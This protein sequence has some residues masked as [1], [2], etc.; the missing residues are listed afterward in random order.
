MISSAAHRRPARPP[1]DDEQRLRARLRHISVAHPQWGWRKAHAIA[2][3]EGLVTNRKRT[4]RLWL[5]EGLERPPRV[6]KKRRIGSARHQRLHATRPDQ[7]WALDFQ[8]GVT[9]EGRQARFLNVIDEY[10][11]EALAPRAA[12]SFTADATVA[13]LDELITGPG[14]RPEHIRMDNGPELTAHALVDWCRYSG[15][16]AAYIDPASPW[17]NGVCESFNGR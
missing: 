14:R 10:T 8:V 5:A 9:A 12:R 4:R 15:V 7:L 13:V 17:Q 3:R 6:R 11:R 16:D 2:V 1:R